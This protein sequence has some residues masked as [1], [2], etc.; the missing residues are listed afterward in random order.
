MFR[1]FHGA[2]FVSGAEHVL[3]YKTDAV[4]TPV[5]L[6]VEWWKQRYTYNPE[7]DRGHQGKNSSVRGTQELSG[8]S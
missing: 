8:K 1:A 4:L 2:S 5:E 7:F 6:T 3:M